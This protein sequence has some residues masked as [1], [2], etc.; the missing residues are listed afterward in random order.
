MP[1]RARFERACAQQWWLAATT[2]YQ[3]MTWTWQLPMAALPGCTYCRL[4]TCP[5]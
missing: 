4:F 5:V 1:R 3:T 2:C